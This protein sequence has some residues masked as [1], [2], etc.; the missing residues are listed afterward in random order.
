MFRVGAKIKVDRETGNTG[1]FVFGLSV[2]TF[3]SNCQLPYL[4]QQ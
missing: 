2:F 4:N 3:A 1:I